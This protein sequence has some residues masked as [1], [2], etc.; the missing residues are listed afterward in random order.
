MVESYLTRNPSYKVVLTGHSLG[1]A[2]ARVTYFFLEDTKRFPKTKYE[3]Y[4][5]GE[6]RVGNYAFADFMNNQNIVSARV[7]AR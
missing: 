5:Y 2:M 4:T 3:L 7:V 6:P 1:A